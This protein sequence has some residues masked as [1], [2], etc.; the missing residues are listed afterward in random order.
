MEE[1][2]EVYRGLRGFYGASEG[3]TLKNSREKV[4]GLSDIDIA[5][6]SEFLMREKKLED[7]EKLI[8]EFFDS[9]FE[10]P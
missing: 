10:F 9:P 8:R 7:F 4:K 3:S 2:L 1:A 6:V 5:V